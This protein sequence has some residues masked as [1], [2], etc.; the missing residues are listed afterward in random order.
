MHSVSSVSAETHI[1]VMR[2]SQDL[3]S[4]QQGNRNPAP[5]PSHGATPT[6]RLRVPGLRGRGVEPPFPPRCGV[7]GWREPQEPGP[8]LQ[9]LKRQCLF[10]EH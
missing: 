8:S 9:S 1:G 3:R 4:D 6:A 2:Q 5:A 10:K 7:L